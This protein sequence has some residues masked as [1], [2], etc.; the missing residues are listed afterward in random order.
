MAEVLSYIWFA[1][2]IIGGI[3]AVA[4][5]FVSRERRRPPLLV[6][7]SCS[8]VAVVLGILSIGIILLVLSATCYI[9]AGRAKGLSASPSSST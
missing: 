7:G 6:A 1:A 4:C 3:A 9:A 5:A 2:A 8:A